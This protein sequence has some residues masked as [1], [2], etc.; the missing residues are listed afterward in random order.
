VGAE[1]T[2]PVTEPPPP[3]PVDPAAETVVEPGRRVVVEQ[4]SPL[5]PYPWWLW[6][7]VALF[8]A[9]AILFLVLW[10]L[11]RGPKTADVPNL[12]GERVVQAQ[13][14]ALARGF[15]LKTVARTASAPAGTVLDQ[16]PQPGADLQRHSQLMAVVSSGRAQVSVPDV[17]GLK[18]TA[19]QKVLTTA[20]LTVQSKVVPSPKPQD[21]VLSQ[22][23]PAGTRVASGSS[24]TLTVAKGPALVTVPALQG[25]TQA[26][27]VAAIQ[28]AGLVPVVIQVPSSQPPGT[29]IAQDPARDQ[30]VQRGSKVRIN[31]SA[32]TSTSTTTFTV[33]TVTTTRTATTRV[34][35]TTQ[36]P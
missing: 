3:P 35:T 22:D 34:T 7:L 33:L 13:R 5:R 4:R 28:N 21:T 32:G 9:L 15:T 8:L 6:L 10:L 29:V 12:V 24:V 23:P 2:P 26:N 11:Q 16:A 30:K 14:D 19:A 36:G 17:A 20:H 1:N 31:V 18:L 27:A 25:L